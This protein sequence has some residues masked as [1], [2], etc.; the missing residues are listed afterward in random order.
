MALG[1]PCDLPNERDSRDV[2]AASRKP[3]KSATASS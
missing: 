2:V 1:R 3:R